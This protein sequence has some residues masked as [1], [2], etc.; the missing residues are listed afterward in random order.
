MIMYFFKFNIVIARVQQYIDIENYIA[1]IL[2][3]QFIANISIYQ[4]IAILIL[5]KLI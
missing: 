4:F 5:A 3:Y 2:L 1:N